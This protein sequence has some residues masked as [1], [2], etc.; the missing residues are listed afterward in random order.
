MEKDMKF[1]KMDLYMMEHTIMERSMALAPINGKISPVIGVNGI[2]I[3]LMVWG[4][5]FG[6]MENN[7]KVNGV[8][9]ICMV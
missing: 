4:T 9:T 5:I 7:T 1:G 6:M 8:I 2:I 3:R